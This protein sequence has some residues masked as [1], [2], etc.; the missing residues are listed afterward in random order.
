MAVWYER[1]VH[2]RIRGKFIGILLIAAV[3]PLSIALIAI[4]ILGYRYYKGEHGRSLQSMASF[5]A[6]TIDYNLSKE[7]EKLGD[8]LELSPLISFVSAASAAAAPQTDTELA[9]AA[10]DLDRQWPQLTATSPA[11][12]ALLTN[13]LAQAL[14]QLQ[15]VNPLFAEILVTDNR[16]RLIAATQKTT[17]FWQADEIWW[18]RARLVR[19]GRVYLEG[20]HY[21]ESARVYS[22]DVCLPV[23]AQAGAAAAPVGIL[24]AVLNSSPLFSSLPGALAEPGPSRQV[25]NAEGDVLFELYS[26]MARRIHGRIDATAAGPLTRPW[27]GW[28][29]TTLADDTRE[30][31]G[32]A[33]IHPGSPLV[34]PHVPS[35]FTPLFVI[36]HDD[37]RTVLAPVRRQILLLAASGIGLILVFTWAGYY[38]A[39][40]KI[41]GPI[42]VLRGAAMSLSQSARVA[43]PESPELPEP[44]SPHAQRVL[45]ELQRITTR[46]EI[47][48]LARD[49]GAMSRRVLSYHEQL[50]EEIAAQTASIQED[51]QFAREFQEALMPRSYPQVSSRDAA[52]P[53][54]LNFHHVY[55]PTSS[56]GGDFFDVLKLSD[57][58][59]G[60]FIADVMGHGA[61]SALVTAILR[62]L[63]QDFAEHGND[64]ARFLSLI[65]QHFINITGQGNQFVFVSA[66]YLVV[67]AERSL[68]TYASAGHPSPF[69]ADRAGH[70]VT[71][72]IERLENN[73]ALGLFPHSAY[74]N[75]TSALKADDV[76][77]LFTDGVFEAGDGEGEQFGRE[78]LRRAIEENLDLD[79]HGLCQSV[80]ASLNEFTGS[81]TQ[82]DDICIVGVEVT[83]T[84]SP[85][86]TAPPPGGQ[87][88]R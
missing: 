56:V 5:L 88:G 24:K 3:V 63:L 84:P 85:A 41:I 67:D 69:L 23:V 62:T 77:V 33:P 74:T 38:I 28:T 59:A 30:L 25:I 66:F 57:S 61:R 34:D 46:D 82:P 40:R 39:T 10:A 35:G 83:A 81:T 12:A 51:L 31:V 32:H 54:R 53:L 72:L 8:W 36:V 13:E 80:V 1:S 60:V 58:R 48:D 75:F 64:P 4:E 21:D 44:A 37:I 19:S 55:K 42:E 50:E 86:F 22:V 6:T 11:V 20:I 7:V 65:N 17:D 9:A 45:A 26:R 49:F 47:E 43:G 15:R 87:P 78:R 14:R 76:F 16:G 29:T 27:A 70:R 2:V 73:P 18:Q 71:P 68:A 79:V 52:R